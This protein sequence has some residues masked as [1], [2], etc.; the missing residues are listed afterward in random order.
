MLGR[1]G[2]PIQQA[3]YADGCFMSGA[4]AVRHLTPSL[5]LNRKLSKML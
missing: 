5:D 2:I 3:N 4:L 1:K